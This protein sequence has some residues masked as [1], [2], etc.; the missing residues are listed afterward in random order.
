[1]LEVTGWVLFLTTT[2]GIH[3]NIPTK[4]LLHFVYHLI[5]SYV[6][7]R[8]QPQNVTES[9]LNLGFAGLQ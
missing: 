5:L 3:A 2:S 1:M 4:F 9:N 6:H 7:C 8:K